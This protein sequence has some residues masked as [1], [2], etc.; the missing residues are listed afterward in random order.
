MP[1]HL[2]HGSLKFVLFTVGGGGGFNA[3]AT[4]SGEGGETKKDGVLPV[5]IKQLL[6]AED[7]VTMFGTQYAMVNTVAIVRD[8][9]YTSTK[10]TYRLEDHTGQIDAHFWL[11]SDDTSKVPKI[12][13]NAYARVIGGYRNTGDQK[14]IIVYSASE[15]THINEITTHLLEVLHVRYKAEKLKHGGN[16]SASQRLPETSGFNFAS[17]ATAMETDAAASDPYGLSGKNLLVYQAIKAS[18]KDFE[19]GIDRSTIDSKFPKI[20]R[21]EMDQIIDYMATEGMIYTTL[22]SDH[23]LPCD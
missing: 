3:N 12:T 16:V 18:A 11:E 1:F 4:T 21:A 23:F 15:V 8:I 9:N 22:D 10:I 6:L 7:K 2:L 5:V 14:A 13:K 19:Q 17:N 20:P